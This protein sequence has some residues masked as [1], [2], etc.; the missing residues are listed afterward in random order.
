MWFFLK[1][2]RD[3]LII[4]SNLNMLERS[5]EI[6]IVVSIAFVVEHADKLVSNTFLPT[7]IEY[8]LRKE[9]KYSLK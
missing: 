7:P 8:S 5:F 6:R 1:R 2:K 4:Y 9:S 3:D